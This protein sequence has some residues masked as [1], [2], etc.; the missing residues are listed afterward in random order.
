MKKFFSIG[1]IRGLLWQVVGTGIGVGIVTLVRVLMG[2]P[3]WK[4]E[5]ATVF[6]ALLGVFFF[7]AGVGA[8]TDW[9]K[10]AMGEE[11]EEMPDESNLGAM[12][13]FGVSLDHKVIGIQYMVFAIILMSVGG[14]FALIFRTELAETGMQFLTLMEYNTLMSLHGIVMIVSILVGIAAIMNYAVPLLIGARD[15]AFP[16]LNAF[17]FWIAVPSGLV[18][19]SS[20]NQ[21]LFTLVALLSFI[22]STPRIII[23]VSIRC[24]RLSNVF[25]ASRIFSFRIPMVVAAR[26]AAMVL[27]WLCFPFKVKS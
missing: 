15:M 21:V 2:L 11:V 14:V 18:M 24:S 26:Q 4:A 23:T 9:Y 20:A 6:G 3:A 13:Y 22:N 17:S 7:L 19:L 27:Y 8:F 16:R 1:L 25:T 12:R 5:P 10:M